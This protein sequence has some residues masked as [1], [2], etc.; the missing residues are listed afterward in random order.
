MGIAKRLT[1]HVIRE[2]SILRK[3]DDLEVR[4]VK[5]HGG[6]GG[7]ARQQEIKETG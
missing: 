2:C 5:G 3:V 4:M 7:K 6:D 1:S